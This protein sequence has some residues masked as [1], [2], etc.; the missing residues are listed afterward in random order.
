[1]N[2]EM[3]YKLK[4]LKISGFKS[5][6]NEQNIYFGNINVLIGANGVGKSNLVSFFQMLNYITTGGLQ[7]FIGKQ[8]Y[9]DSLLYFGSRTTEQF[10]AQLRFENKTWLSEYSFELTHSYQGQMMFAYENIGRM[11][12]DMTNAKRIKMNTLGTGHQES[13]LRNNTT[14]QEAKILLSVLGRCRAYQFHDTS[15]K[16]FIRQP[17][18]IGDNRYLKSDAGNL[19]AYLYEMRNNKTGMKY[20]QRIVSRIQKIMPQFED[21]FLEPAKENPNLIKLEWSHEGRQHIFGAHQISD[22]SLRFM[23]LATLL[24]QPPDNLPNLIVIDEPELGLHPEALIDLVGMIKIASQNSQII[25]STQSSYLLDFFNVND[26]IVV[27]TKEGNSDFS[28]LD[29]QKLAEWISNYT[30]AEL[31]NKNIIGG[32]P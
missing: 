1:M 16:A 12:V 29:E 4:S 32:R 5:I 24:L 30:M 20:Y 17:G 28:R 22:G 27:D 9:A 8:G 13:L 10:S 6:G 25:L 15:D 21:F 26:I 11:H 3:R 2:N 23:A 7:M 19:G 31:W 14:N 18:S